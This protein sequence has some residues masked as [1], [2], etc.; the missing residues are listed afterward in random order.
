MR[1][2]QAIR[3]PACFEINAK[4]R[5]THG[6]IESRTTE[7]KPSFCYLVR[8]Q[9]GKEEKSCERSAV[10][11]IGPSHRVRPWFRSARGWS[12]SRRDIRRRRCLG[13]LS[14]QTKRSRRRARDAGARLT[15]RC[16][17]RTEAPARRP[18]PIVREGV[19]KSYE[20][21]FALAIDE[22]MTAEKAVP[23][24]IAMKWNKQADDDR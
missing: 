21:G 11:A 13:W 3:G 10:T 19:S 2:L 17:P 6:R 20:V 16:D 12:F 4:R 15:K 7:R 14:C 9:R 18:A 5:R 22:G 1:E 23:D 8:F 24:A